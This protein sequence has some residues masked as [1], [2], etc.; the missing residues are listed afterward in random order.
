MKGKTRGRPPVSLDP[1][2]FEAALVKFR[3]KET[4]AAQAAKELGISRITLFRKIK[5][6]SAKEAV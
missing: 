1:A 5:E 2:E 6:R 4:T 3:A